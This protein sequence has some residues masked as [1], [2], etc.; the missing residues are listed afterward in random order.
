MGKF[1]PIPPREMALQLRGGAEGLRSG[2]VGLGVLS[3]SDTI[4]AVH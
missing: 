2:S 3:D 4:W 1:S